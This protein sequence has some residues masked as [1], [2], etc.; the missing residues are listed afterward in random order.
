MHGT[1]NYYHSLGAS[2]AGLRGATYSL[3][4]ISIIPEPGSTTLMSGV[5][6]LLFCWVVRGRRR[7]A[8]SNI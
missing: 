6:V 4:E 8:V 2:E 1:L 5:A 3:D 7:S